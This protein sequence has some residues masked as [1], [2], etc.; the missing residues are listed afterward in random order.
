M[1]GLVI[2]PW[3]VLILRGIVA[4]AFGV[5]AF[6]WPGI[7]LLA[8]ITLYAAY[9][10][11]GGA[12]AVFGAVSS[13]KEKSD[14]G[15]LLL[16]GIVGIAAGAIA[17]LH[18]GLTALILVLLIGAHALVMG[19]L[20]II[21]AIRERGALG[22]RLLLGLAGLFSGIFGI[23]V[24]LFP[25]PGALALV[26]LISLYSVLFGAL[27]IGAAFSL[28]GQRQTTYVGPE[29]RVNPPERRSLHAH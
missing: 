15:L 8:L 14:W 10:L 25:G 19:V 7:T 5:L 9:A 6:L 12:V 17:F 26:W 1:N 29:R 16:L 3:W 11:I 23:L 27:L 28:R 22:G 13:A 21:S 20:D 18:P 4:V 24:F 2:Q